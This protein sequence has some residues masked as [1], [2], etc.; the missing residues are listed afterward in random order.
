[1]KRR[2]FITLLGGAAAWP[3]VAKAQQ[4]AMPVIGWMSGRS[5]ADSTHLL[6]A[7]RKGLHDTGYV[8]GES[9]SIEYRWA[10]GDYGRLPEL[11][12]DLVN[13][14]VL[15][16]MAVGGEP[17][18]IA[19]KKATS[20]I[21]IVFGIGGD[22]VDAGL[23][24]SFNRP[25]GNA[26][27]YTLLTSQME[28]K[29]IGLLHE[30]APSA[31]SLGALI[32]PAFPPA[33]RQLGDIENATKT[34]RQSLF[35]ARASTD[36]E[37]D[38]AFAS[39]V[40]QRVGAVLIAADPYFDTRREQIIA[41]AAQ[42]RLPTMYQFREFAVA[43]GLISYGPSYTDSYKQGGIYA[44]RI[45][46]GAKPAD[47]PI[48]QPTKFEMVINLKTANSLGLN[49]PNSMQLLADEVIE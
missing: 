1:M 24:A 28:P 11:A 38:A 15:L 36:A 22:P 23:V 46:R 49:I 25:G 40:Q 34:I 7:F 19:A 3:L 45:L 18:A 29:R 6:E 31:S 30:L 48:L 13:R 9:I 17:S 5:P 26:T 2:Q 47:L 27:G 10:Q 8:E 33:V 43:G 12:S 32:N 37:L 16:L 42:A 35:V 41:L 39:F 20:T 21:P 44:G 4:P 14:G